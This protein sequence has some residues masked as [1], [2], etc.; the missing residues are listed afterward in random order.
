MWSDSDPDP[1][2]GKCQDLDPNIM[3]LDPQ[4]CKKHLC[5][6]FIFNYFAVW[7]A[8]WFRVARRGGVWTATNWPIAVAKPS[9]PH[10]ASSQSAAATSPPLARG[11]LSWSR[12]TVTCWPGW[13]RGSV[14]VGGAPGAAGQPVT[15]QLPA[16]LTRYKSLY[17]IR[18]GQ[19][20]GHQTGHVQILKKFY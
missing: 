9:A 6:K 16:R 10:P 14:A 19:F 17:L 5:W 15:H 2:K 8:E 4:P 3:S 18:V 12:R 13:V 11:W 1:N 20:T 7:M